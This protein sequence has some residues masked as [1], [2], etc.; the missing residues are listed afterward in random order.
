MSQDTLIASLD[1]NKLAYES[2]LGAKFLCAYL[3]CSDEMQE[4]VRDTLEMLNDPEIDEE[5]RQMSLVTLADALLPNYHKGELGLDYE[6]SER[7]AADKF[8]EF[9]ELVDELDRE[10]ASFSGNLE[11]V[12]GERGISQTE[13]A[14]KIGVGQPAISNMLARN[15]R[16]QRRTIERLAEALGVQPEDLWGE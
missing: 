3:E 8:P 7:E 11:R 2:L 16:P 13:L 6:K 12:M 14:Q 10:E 1:Q 15:C 9:R 4:V 5:D